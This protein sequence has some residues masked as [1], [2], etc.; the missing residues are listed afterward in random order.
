MNSAMHTESTPKHWYTS[1]LVVGLICAA[2]LVIVNWSSFYTYCVSPFVQGWDGEGH[3]AI[4]QYYSE[5]IFPATWGWV[6]NWYFGMP[7][8]QFYTPLLALITATLSH[9]LPFL[10]FLTIFKACSVIITLCIPFLL[11]WFVSKRTKSP[12]SL[13]LTGLTA[14]CAMSAAVPLVGSQGVTV[15]STFYTGLISHALGFAL[16][17]VW[18]HYFLHAESDRKAR[19][20]SMICL[21]GVFLSDV[22]VVVFAFISYVV[23]YLYSLISR[24]RT[25]RHQH[26]RLVWK[27]LLRL[28][29]LYLLLGGV[30]LLMTAFWTIPVFAR[31]SYFVTGPLSNAPGTV[32]LLTASPAL[33]LLFLFS[34]GLSFYYRNKTASILSLIIACS[35]VVMAW[36]YSNTVAHIPVHGRRL[37]GSFLFLLPIIMGI[38][39][40]QF[41]LHKKNMFRSIVFICAIGCVLIYSLDF[42]RAEWGGYYTRYADDSLSTIVDYVSHRPIPNTSVVTEMLTAMQQPQ[43]FIFDGLL[44]VAGV[45]VPVHVLRESSINS[46]FLTP[47]RNGLS[48]DWEGWGFTSFLVFDHDF[49]SQNMVDQLD[50][51]ARVGI[52]SFLVRS[53][54][55][56]QRLASSSQIIM[57][58]DMGNWSLYRFKQDIPRAEVL[59]DHPPVPLFTQVNFKRRYVDSYDWTRFQE[60]L[61]FANENGITFVT[62]RD[63]NLDTSHEF[64]TSKVVVVSSYTY[65][66]EKKALKRLITFSKSNH[67]ILVADYDPLFFDLKEV[68]SSNPGLHVSIYD[69]LSPT[70]LNGNP[71]RQQMQDIFSEIDVINGGGQEG[72][73]R[74][75]ATDFKQDT[76]HVTMSTST[77]VAFPVIIKSSY[78]PD[79]KRVDGK[80]I[81]MASPGFMLTYA[82][83]SFDLVFNTPREVYGGYAITLIAGIWYIMYGFRIFRK[84]K[85]S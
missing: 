48:H 39:S 32:M 36:D 8:P 40:E 81:Y 23:I 60:E 79:W 28:N 82:T 83:S 19:V 56:K 52:Q 68:A 44:G 21:L 30:P 12:Y 5:N 26:I 37:I 13:W 58:H 18:L 46:L 43:S 1:S 3:A 15:L 53:E 22:H 4:T 77:D 16:Y 54:D 75:T 71:L 24:I 67:L 14:V 59:S 2:L 25:Y 84:Q 57:E 38:I 63:M 42:G 35:F 70:V 51:A 47:L 17:I 69:K 29:G 50:R 80:P 55:M 78:F 76:I 49:I 34:I 65:T 85:I 20:I 9:L 66:D 6:P 72:V 64:D 45:S 31:Y 73:Q 62:P 74:V 7:F 27:D 61:L 11:I 10:S 41:F 33:T